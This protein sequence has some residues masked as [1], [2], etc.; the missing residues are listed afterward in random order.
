M[1]DIHISVSDNLDQVQLKLTCNNFKPLT[2]DMG[3]PIVI[4]FLTSLTVYL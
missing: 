1:L 2:N 4:I 3:E